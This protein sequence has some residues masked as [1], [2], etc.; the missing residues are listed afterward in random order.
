MYAPFC[1]IFPR[2]LVFA[3]CHCFPRFAM[4]TGE[5]GR[6]AEESLKGV[7]EG[8]FEFQRTGFIYTERLVS[9]SLLMGGRERTGENYFRACRS[10]IRS[11]G[12]GGYAEWWLG[13]L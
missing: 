4:W 5:E 9:V 3:V 13:D 2:I 12:V 10:V 8:F 7:E 6:H 11:R 1:V